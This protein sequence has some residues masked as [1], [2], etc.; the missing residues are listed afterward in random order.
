MTQD[1]RPVGIVVHKNMTMTDMV[2]LIISKFI[3]TSKRNGNLT[4]QISGE[5][6]LNTMSI[7]IAGGSLVSGG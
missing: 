4:S 7:R 1:L 5:G 6:R 3:E 2:A